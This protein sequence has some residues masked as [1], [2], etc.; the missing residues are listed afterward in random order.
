[1]APSESDLIAMAERIETTPFDRLDALAGE[2]EEKHDALIDWQGCAY[3]CRLWGIQSTST[4]NTGF[5]MRSW[6]AAARRKAQQIARG[7]L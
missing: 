1:M 7:S 2:L 5:A 3:R 4:A 6:A